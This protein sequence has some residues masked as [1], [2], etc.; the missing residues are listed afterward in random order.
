MEPSLEAKYSKLRRG[1]RLRR[2]K[3][4]S[5]RVDVLVVHFQFEVQMRTGC[6]TCHADGAD[7]VALSDAKALAQA[8]CDRLQMR[9]Q[10][11]VLAVVL[12]LYDVAVAALPA[13][14]NDDAFG[15]RAHVVPAA[16]E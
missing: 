7:R 8:G 15:D 12:N 6:P 3:F 11:C 4:G 5:Q 13:G 9:I 1:Q 10:R 14:E 2:G 16:A